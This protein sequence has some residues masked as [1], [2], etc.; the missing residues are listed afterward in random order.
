LS[1]VAV[2]FVL[3]V[4]SD[5]QTP[6][7]T[8]IER[9]TNREIL[10]RLTAPVG[11]N[12]RIDAS[13]NLPAWSGLVTLQSTGVNQHGDSAAPYLSQRFYR[14]AQLD[15]PGVFI[16]DHL[17][18]QNGDL[19]IHPIN[20]ASFVMSWNGTTIYNDPV[21]AAT[22]YTGLPRAN[23]ILIT[24]IHTDHFDT[25]TLNSVTGATCV[26]LAPQAVA[27]SMGA[28]LRA[29][30]TVLTN[31][32]SASVGAIN[33]DAVP[34]YNDRH[35]LGTGNGYVLT[36]GGK[37]IYIAGDTGDI[38]EM[39]AMTNID[40]AFVPMNLP[41]TM[42]VSNAVSAARAFQPKVVYPYHYSPSTPVSDVNL[43]KSLVG[44]DLGIEV[45][46]RKWY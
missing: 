28:S 43:F 44:A 45:R 25:T 3:S 40:V 22:R 37:R 35:P 18:T 26:I 24:H 38:A 9:L 32:A 39:R 8:G 34:A 5:A 27:N 19:V 15:G 17:A 4:S 7:F 6:Q 2:L 36:L 13:T 20:H 46:L 31:G 11:L 12:Y 23:L 10:L 21:G 14:A 1:V 41:F 42:S 33:I 30:T 16:G 29:L